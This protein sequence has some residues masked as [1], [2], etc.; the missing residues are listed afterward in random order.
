MKSINFTNMISYNIF[1]FVAQ[2]VLCFKILKP[3]ILLYVLTSIAVQVKSQCTNTTK[4]PTAN[5]QASIFNEVQIIT[6]Q[7]NAGQYF[8]IQGLVIGK[9][10]QFASSNAGD[11]I[12]V[13]DKDG[14]ILKGSGNTPFSYTVVGDDI[15][16]V[17]IN[18]ISPACG[19]QVV[20]RTTTSQ[21]TTCQSIPPHVG[22]A[23]SV[24]TTTLDINGKLRV[25]DDPNL[26]TSGMIR[27]NAAQQDFEGYDGSTWRSF[28]KSSAP[29]G[30]FPKTDLIEKQK[31]I[32][33]DG[34]VDDFFGSSV[35]ISGDYAVIGAYGDDVANVDQ[36]S[37]YIFRR[38][39]SSWSQVAKLTASDGAASDNF[40]RSVSISGDYAII[41]ADMDDVG[42][43][44][45]QGSAYIF[46]RSGNSWTQEAQLTAS[47]GALYDFFGKS[48]SISSDYVVIGAWGDDIGAN[49]NQGSA[50]IFK[51]IGS[52]WSQE[53]KLTAADGAV[54]DFLGYSVSIA[55]DYAVI[56]SYGDDIGAIVDQG[57]SYIFKRSGILWTQEAKLTAADGATNDFFGYSVSMAG[58]YVIIGAFGDDIGTFANQGSSYIFKRNGIL[59]PQEA[60]LIASD[61]TAGESFGIS[62]SISG[63]YVV[64]GPDE[65]DIEPN[66]NQGSAYIYKRNG[67]SW[68]QESK[69]TASDGASSDFFG[70]S[71]SISGDYAII[72]AWVDDVGSNTNQGS[73]YFFNR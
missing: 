15:V 6:S 33:D 4:F 56:G 68:I 5:I 63:D 30:N 45:N 24:P 57:S 13:R 64:I 3:V 40:G 2:H 73:V 20:N 71:V 22:V 37:A 42:D 51:R 49:M 25:S 52:S 58:D 72:G 14:L 34:K 21:C 31:G 27:W 12:T 60:K 39:G 70:N 44:T 26:P 69:F 29:W 46:K 10:Y 54:D 16:S 17:H 8:I 32:A 61:G 48:V 35:S 47:D 18:V 23:T 67:T 36:G 65:D 1:S 11:F 43:N 55:G 59:W 38:I 53:A 19:S 7:Q 9:I 62:V 28:T 50:Y 41:G 66:A